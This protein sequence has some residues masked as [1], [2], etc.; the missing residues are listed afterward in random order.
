LKKKNKTLNYSVN[1]NIIS[2]RDNFKVK[3]NSKYRLRSGIHEKKVS[4]K[5]F[6]KLMK[7]KKDNLN[8]TS[9]LKKNSL[10]NFKLKKKLK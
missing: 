5:I 9:Q 10:N 3:N 7:N 8:I 2:P 6:D 4:M 1:K